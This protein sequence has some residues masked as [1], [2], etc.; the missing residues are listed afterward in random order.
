MVDYNRTNRI[1]KYIRENPNKIQEELVESFYNKIP[2][3]SAKRILKYL[4]DK[5]IILRDKNKRAYKIHPYL[6]NINGNLLDLQQHI[7]LRLRKEKK[8]KKI[9]D[10][11]MGLEMVLR[12][13]TIQE[14]PLKFNFGSLER[15]LDIRFS[16]E[17]NLLISNLFYSFMREVIYMNPELWPHKIKKFEFK[18]GSNLGDKIEIINIINRLKENYEKLGY[19]PPTSQSPFRR[20]EQTILHK[21]HYK[22]AVFEQFFRKREATKNKNTTRDLRKIANDVLPIALKNIEGIFSDN[23]DFAG[24]KKLMNKNNLTMEERRNGTEKI[25]G[26]L[27]KI[28]ENIL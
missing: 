20:E 12:E 2:G 5:K 11:S 3:T 14:I 28:K 23:Q 16:D 27:K 7:K 6:E 18:I 17:T 9:Y 13:K 19:I 21:E 8:L 10:S 4:V 22:D 1:I 15:N 26:I 24:I 25:V